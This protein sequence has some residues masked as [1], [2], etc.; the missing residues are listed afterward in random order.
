MRQK[1]LVVLFCSLMTLGAETL[2]QGERDR[3]MS[4]LHATRKLF[5][6]AT[7]NLSEAQWSFKPG[8]AR[9]SVAECAEHLAE[10]E[11]FLRGLLT[12]TLEK[13]PVDEAKREAR[14]Q[15]REAMDAKVAAMISDRTQKAQAP[16]PL[17]PMGKLGGREQVI[18]LFRQRRDETITMVEQTKGDLR[19]RYFAMSPAVEM[20]LYQMFFMISA[21]T[22]RH[23]KQMREVMADPGFPK[24]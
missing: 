5:V 18:G 4:H 21:H 6:D 9:W 17:R 14:R 15:D 20:D 2:G 10:S 7:A 1:S 12:G 23:V 22:E 13:A 19:G 3:A 16:E 8:P 24:R 11:T